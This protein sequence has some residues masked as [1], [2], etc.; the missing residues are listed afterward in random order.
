VFSVQI[1]LYAEPVLEV[2]P[3]EHLDL[4]GQLRLSDS[5]PVD[6]IGV[7]AGV[8]SSIGVSCCEGATGELQQAYVRAVI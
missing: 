4:V 1:D 5:S 3:S 2:Q 8:Q 7:P 6:V